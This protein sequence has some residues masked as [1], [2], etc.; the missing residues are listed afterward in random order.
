MRSGG[1][2]FMSDNSAVVRLEVSRKLKCLFIDG[3]NV[4]SVKRFRTV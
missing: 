2:L 3:E 1:L 4:V